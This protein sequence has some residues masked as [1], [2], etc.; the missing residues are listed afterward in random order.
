[1]IIWIN[2]SFSVTEYYTPFYIIRIYRTIP[3][4]ATSLCSNKR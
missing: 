3:N 4:L 2:L 1:M